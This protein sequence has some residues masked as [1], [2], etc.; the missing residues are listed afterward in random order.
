MRLIYAAFSCRD[1]LIHPRE[2]FGISY[3]T[4]IGLPIQQDGLSYPNRKGPIQI[5][6][7]PYEAGLLKKGE[8]F[9]SLALS[10]SRFYYLFCRGTV[11]FG[12]S[13]YLQRWFLIHP[14]AHTSHSSCRHARHLIFFFRLVRD[15]RF[16]CKQ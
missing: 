14:S 4:G 11:P 2:N 6:E 10:L 8:A 15:Q 3:P 5:K 16:G 12:D 13:P 7:G 1:L 9:L